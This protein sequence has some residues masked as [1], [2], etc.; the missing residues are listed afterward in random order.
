MINALY[1]LRS[2]MMSVGA[3]LPVRLNIKTNSLTDVILFS[4]PEAAQRQELDWLIKDVLS[5]SSLTL[6]LGC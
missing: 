2:R 6:Q 3:L 4:T 5:P 1:T